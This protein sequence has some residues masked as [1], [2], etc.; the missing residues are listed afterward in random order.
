MAVVEGAVVAHDLAYWQQCWET[1][2]EELD[3]SQKVEQQLRQVLETLSK[4]KTALEADNAKIRAES[5]VD[6]ELRRLESAVVATTDAQAAAE[7]RQEAL[8]TSMVQLRSEHQE[9]EARLTVGREEIAEAREAQEPLREAQKLAETRRETAQE[10][11]KSMVSVDTLERARHEAA[12][13]RSRLVQQEEETARLREALADS[14]ASRVEPEPQKDGVGEE[15][16]ALDGVEE[17]L[18]WLADVQKTT[19]AE[20]HRVQKLERTE[21]ALQ[22]KLRQKSEEHAALKSARVDLGDAGSAMR[23]A[24]ARQSEGY[25][26]RVDDLVEARRLMDADRE[27][28]TSE[29]AELQ[30]QLDEM[31][32]DLASMAELEGRHS[33]LEAEQQALARECERLRTMNGVFGVQLLGDAAV[34]IGGD[35]AAAAEAVSRVLTLQKR[36]TERREDHD[37]EKNKLVERIRG[38]EQQNSRGGLEEDEP[39]SGAGRPGSASG[40]GRGDARSKKAPESTLEAVS[41]SAR[42]AWRG[43]LGMLRE[44]VK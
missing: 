5:K 33:Q 35:A 30:A 18:R 17:Q 22:Q 23:E 6:A 40:Q 26:K 7:A 20:V 36:F 28:L 1:D 34:D 8:E 43:G 16:E 37:R 31:A 27:K 10:K 19:A 32:P 9:A 13:A 12:A 3:R 29:C 14:W 4:K 41:S 39:G 25:V 38:L 15:L 42:S 44:A 2:G 24:L 21:M 11:A